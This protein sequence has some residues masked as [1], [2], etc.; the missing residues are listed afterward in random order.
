[1]PKSIL[2][3]I[4]LDHDALVPS[5]LALAHRLLDAGGRITLVTV[6]EKIPGYTQEF[7][8]VK[9]ENHLS[10]RVIEQLKVLAADDAAIDV[11][12]ISGKAGMAISELAG[13][14]ACDLIIVG[15]HSPGLQG[16][17]L[18]STAARIVRRAPCSVLV[19]RN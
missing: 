15:S 6:L 2:I 7:V 9:S 14:M 10:Q 17:F 19:V 3:P 12:V 4:A 5:K 11:K 1:M 16:Y 13:D 8:T 18:G